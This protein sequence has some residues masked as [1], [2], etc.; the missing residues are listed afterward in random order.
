MVIL[1]LQAQINLSAKDRNEL[2][3][4]FFPRARKQEPRAADTLIS[5][6]WEP[7]HV[8]ETNRVYHD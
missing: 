4:G 6:L 3:N 1:V 8:A 7:M 2:G 5:D